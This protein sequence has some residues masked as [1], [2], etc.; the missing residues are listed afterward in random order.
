MELGQVM[1]IWPM[2]VGAEAIY[3]T[4]DAYFRV[5]GHTQLTLGLA[6]IRGLLGSDVGVYTNYTEVGVEGSYALTADARLN[7]FY[8]VPF[9]NMVILAR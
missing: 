6:D 3:R 9:A 2:N 5:H 1:E 7:A 8:F 4:D